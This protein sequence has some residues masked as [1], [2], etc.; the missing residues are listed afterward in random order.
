MTRANAARWVRVLND[1]H[2]ALRAMSIALLTL[3]LLS[4][5]ASCGGPQDPNAIHLR[6]VSPSWAS[7]DAGARVAAAVG[8]AYGGQDVDVT[9]AV[10]I[11]DG[12]VVRVESCTA[13]P[14]LGM[15]AV[16]V[17]YFLGHPRQACVLHA[18]RR[19]CWDLDEAPGSGGGEP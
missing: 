14:T 19:Q 4:A 3:S 11:S 15:R 7:T 9:G 8:L 1:A 5:M 13:V 18:G 16:C 17:E 2:V 6:S 12:R 10:V